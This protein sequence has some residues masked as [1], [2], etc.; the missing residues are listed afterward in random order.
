[1][2]AACLGAEEADDD[3][4]LDCGSGGGAVSTVGCLPRTGGAFA[5]EEAESDAEEDDAEE[6][7]DEEPQDNRM[8]GPGGFLLG[9]CVCVCGWASAA[10]MA[11]SITM[12]P[13][14]DMDSL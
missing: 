7:A 6:D 3:W 1:M 2:G 13:E 9:D 10:R 8:G 14:E 12:V 11:S 4:G 5:D